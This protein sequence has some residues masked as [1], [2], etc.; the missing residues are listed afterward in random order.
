MKR[1][2]AILF[3]A[4]LTAHVGAQ[5]PVEGTTYYLPQT[6]LRFSVLVEKTTFQPGELA[7]YA[8]RYMKLPVNDAPDTNYRIVGISMSLYAMPDTSRQFQ[9]IIDRK[10]TVISLERDENGVLK[11][12]NAKGRSVAQP[13]P[14]RPARKPHA[15]N[16]RDYMTED[17]L[18]S[19]SSAK[20]AEL[21]AREIYDIRDSRNMLSRGEADFM[22]K[23]GEQLKI[24][25]DNLNTQEHALLQ[26][27]AGTT[28]TD[29]T[30]H[31]IDFVPAK[32][33]QDQVLFR[34]SKK[35]GMVDSDDLAGIPYY[36][37]IKDLHAIP[38]LKY[39]NEEAAKKSKEDI[40]INV[41][42]PGKIQITVSDGRHPVASF[43]TYAA[44]FGRVEPLSANLWSKKF[45]TRL[46]LNPVTGT[47]ESLQTEPLE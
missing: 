36:I 25:L 45:I 9:A 10:H 34:F 24:M 42:L 17:I 2:L 19:G 46:V 16:P 38:E 23:D 47:V 26:E 22:P 43:E 5:Q 30:Q 32:E 21:I 3:L 11:A 6:C 18:A 1:I 15:L 20:M 27:F 13:E 29:T 39:D 41:T 8:E 31:F 12:V 33:V 44:Q 7:R 4:A 37:N 35:L 14:F 40:G 28:E